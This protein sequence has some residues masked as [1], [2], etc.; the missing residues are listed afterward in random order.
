MPMNGHYLLLFLIAVAVVS[1][2]VWRSKQ[3]K[4]A[5]QSSNARRPSEAAVH[6]EGDQGFDI[7]VATGAMGG[8]VNDAATVKFALDR[9]KEDGHQPDARDIGFAL[10]M[11]KEISQNPPDQT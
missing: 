11:E 8:S 1:L 6:P 4:R 9:V 7:G 3:G 2:V 10:G 5:S